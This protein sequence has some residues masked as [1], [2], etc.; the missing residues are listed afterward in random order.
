MPELTDHAVPVANV[1]RVSRSPASARLPL[2]LPIIRDLLLLAEASLIG[3]VQLVCHV[4]YYRLLLGAYL[5]LERYGRFALFNALTFLLVRWLGAWSHAFDPGS[6]A[7]S[8]RGSV[9]AIV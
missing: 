8:L 1:P 2:S 7:R 6:F 5:E 9:Q 4:A 3:T